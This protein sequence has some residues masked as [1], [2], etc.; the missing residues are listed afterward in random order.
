MTDNQMQRRY[1]ENYINVEIQILAKS[2]TPETLKNLKDED[3][4]K[5]WSLMIELEIFLT[6]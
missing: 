5:I 4:Y 2:V 1:V 6:M 3:L